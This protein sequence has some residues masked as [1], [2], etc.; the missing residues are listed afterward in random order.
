TA[1]LPPS[2]ADGTVPAPEEVSRVGYLRSTLAAVRAFAVDVVTEFY[3]IVVQGTAAAIVTGSAAVL[4][5]QSDTLLALATKLP[6]DWA[7]VAE[8]LTWLRTLPLGA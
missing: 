8:F 1:A 4:L 2:A 6:A 7:W 5:A 3:K